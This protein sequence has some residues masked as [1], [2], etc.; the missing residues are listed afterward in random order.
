MI[1]NKTNQIKLLFFGYPSNSA[2]S[3]TGGHLWMKKVADHIDKNSHY[4]VLKIYNYY[5][6][7]N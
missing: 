7:K 2:T 5:Y 6:D 1:K 4:S 3:Y